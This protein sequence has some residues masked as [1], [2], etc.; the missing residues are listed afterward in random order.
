MTRWA[1]LPQR[2]CRQMSSFIL[3]WYF[4][5]LGAI[6]PRCREASFS[7]LLIIGAVAFL[8]PIIGMTI[9][10]AGLLSLLSNPKSYAVLFGAIVLSKLLCAS[11]WIWQR[12]QKEI[13]ALTAAKLCKKSVAEITAIID[14]L[15]RAHAVRGLCL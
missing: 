11:Y 1:V 14:V 9:D 13:I 10:A 6:L 4:V 12:D 8:V 3:A 7:M 5:P 2:A 15:E